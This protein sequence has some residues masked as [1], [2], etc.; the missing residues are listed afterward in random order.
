MTTW[1]LP[2]RAQ[3]ANPW[4]IRR[5]HRKAEQY[6]QPRVPALYQRRPAYPEGQHGK[7]KHDRHYGPCERG[8]ERAES[9]VQRQ[10]EPAPNQMRNSHDPGTN[11]QPSHQH[12]GLPSPHQQY[13][14]AGQPQ[15]QK[16]LEFPAFTWHLWPTIDR[17][18]A[19]VRSDNT[20]GQTGARQ[21]LVREG[22]K[23]A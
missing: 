14:H 3:A 10:L 11:V 6:P 16:Q 18:R 19:N 8:R 17:M 12:R 23:I 1:I 5:P 7:C 9:H 2:R 20:A 22:V 15:H 21:L 13:R 4:N